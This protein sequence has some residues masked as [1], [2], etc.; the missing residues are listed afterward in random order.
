V[1]YEEMPVH[2]L[3]GVP[4]DAFWQAAG[5]A[6]AICFLSLISPGQRRRLR[7]EAIF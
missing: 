2:K 4:G 5:K 1:R 3:F 7:K 6:S